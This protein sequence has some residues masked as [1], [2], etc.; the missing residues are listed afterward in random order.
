MVKGD[1]AT[2]QPLSHAQKDLRLALGMSETLEHPL[3]IIAT[4]NEIYKQAKRAGYSE[5]DSS[6]KNSLKCVETI[7]YSSFFLGCLFEEQVLTLQSNSIL[8]SLRFCQSK[9]QE[10]IFVSIR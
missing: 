2:N 4:I 1:F 8:F 3:P 6:V 7:V 9:K 5:H 10:E